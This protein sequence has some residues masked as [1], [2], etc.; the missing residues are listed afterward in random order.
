MRGSMLR[1]IVDF[2]RTLIPPERLSVVFV[3]VSLLSI[4]DNIGSLY[5]VDG[6]MLNGAYMLS[7]AKPIVRITPKDL[8]TKTSSVVLLITEEMYRKDF[9]SHSPLDKSMLAKVIKKI[10]AKS[11]D[12]INLDIEVAPVQKPDEKDRE[13]YTQLVSS[14]ENHPINIPVSTLGL[15]SENRKYRYE[16]MKGICSQPNLDIQRISG[17]S[18]H[19]WGKHRLGLRYYPD[20]PTLGLEEANKDF[21]FCNELVLKKYEMMPMRYIMHLTTGYDVVQRNNL[22]LE[23]INYTNARAIEVVNLNSIDDIDQLPNLDGIKVYLGGD[24]ISSTGVDDH[25]L[26][27]IGLVQGTVLHAFNGYTEKNPI[28]SVNGVTELAVD[29]IL[30]FSI[31]ALLSW[32]FKIFGVIISVLVGLLAFGAILY[33]FPWFLSLGLW[34]PP[35]IVIISSASLIIET[36]FGLK[37]QGVTK[38]TMQNLSNDETTQKASIFNKKNIV[39]LLSSLL[40]SISLLTE[41]D[42]GNE[43]NIA[44]LVIFLLSLLAIITSNKAFHKKIQKYIFLKIISILG[45]ALAI[46][47]TFN[48]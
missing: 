16:W 26:S 4:M 24:Y 47:T 20:L 40:L 34:V 6:W 5:K 19:V 9:S 15:N 2:I 43:R 11:P 37:E 35:F 36:I 1:S 45:L 3:L 38:N 39:F 18:S 17:I 28:T 14:S 44:A 27:P 33:L 7:P 46:T 22:E 25:R 13:F 32:V 31:A 8:S 41:F 42:P 30:A 21:L 29:L 23:K 10:S 48:W 12:V